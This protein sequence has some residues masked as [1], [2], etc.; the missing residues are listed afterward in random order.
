MGFI[1]DTFKT[2]YLSFVQKRY[3]LGISVND[4]KS[5]KIESFKYVNILSKRDLKKLL[6]FILN[7]TDV[8]AEIIQ[9]RETGICF[10]FFENERAGQF[11]WSLLQYYGLDY[12]YSN[13]I[14][15]QRRIPNYMLGQLRKN[16]YLEHGLKN[17]KR[18]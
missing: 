17:K 3:I 10:D 8:S 11:F 18:W 9:T 14:I 5:F 7:K 2:I 6:K 13:A 12:G 16:K 15:F 1:F 4:T